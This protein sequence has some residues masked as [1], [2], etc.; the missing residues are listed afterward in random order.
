MIYIAGMSQILSKH[1]IRHIPCLKLG[2]Y[3]KEYVNL[4]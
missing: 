4:A 2:L 1:W 3:E